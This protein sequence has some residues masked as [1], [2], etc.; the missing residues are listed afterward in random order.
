MSHLGGGEEFLWGWDSMRFTRRFLD[1]V[2]F[3]VGGAS[4][5]KGG[6]RYC[7]RCPLGWDGT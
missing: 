6:D 2:K 7:I 4:E 3:R 1:R 5:P